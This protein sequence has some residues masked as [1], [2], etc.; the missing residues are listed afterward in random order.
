M[1][2]S[3]RNSNT[4]G[5]INEYFIF[6]NLLCIGVIINCTLRI[7]KY[8]TE[9]WNNEIRWTQLTFEKISSCNRGIKC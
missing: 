5:I 6:F 3:Y 8:G 2:H 9:R 1:L 4:V 7:L